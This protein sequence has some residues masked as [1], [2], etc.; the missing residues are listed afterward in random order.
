[1]G[2]GLNPWAGH[3]LPV[4]LE[5][6]SKRFKFDPALFRR[7]GVTEEQQR[8]D[9]AVDNPLP[10][11]RADVTLLLPSC[12]SELRELLQRCWDDDPS[13]WR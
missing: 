11:R 8:A 2:S 9:W 3:S 7:Y 10:P 6:V 1:M 4:V 5:K 13:V 12:P